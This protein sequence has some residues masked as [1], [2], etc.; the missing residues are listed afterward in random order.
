MVILLVVGFEN[1]L[2]TTPAKDT[3]LYKYRSVLICC[4]RIYYIRIT[5]W[6]LYSNSG[7]GVSLVDKTV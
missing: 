6:F 7:S 5:M 2:L 4:G 3:N 1:T